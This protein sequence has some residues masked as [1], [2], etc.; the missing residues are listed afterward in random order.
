MQTIRC[1]VVEVHRAMM[2]TRCTQARHSCCL[3]FCPKQQN[4]VCDEEI[5]NQNPRREFSQPQLI[6]P[7]FSGIF[8]RKLP[9]CYFFQVV[10]RKC[11]KI[12]LFLR[13]VKKFLIENFHKI[14]TANSQKL[15]SNLFYVFSL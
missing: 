6:F 11:E 12:S 14:S 13:K 1:S 7:V 9:F 2:C 15:A 4:T 10:F 3:L 8:F 5:F